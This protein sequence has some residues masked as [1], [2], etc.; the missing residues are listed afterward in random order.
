MSKEVQKQ[1]DSVADRL[2]EDRKT[3]RIILGETH[4]RM[5]GDRETEN[6]RGADK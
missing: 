6:R 4:G 5:D 2:A 1:P 3:E